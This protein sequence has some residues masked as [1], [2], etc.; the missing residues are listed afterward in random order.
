MYVF[1]CVCV[2]GCSDVVLRMSAHEYIV[3]PMHKIHSQGRVYRMCACVCACWYGALQ[4][5][6]YVVDPVYTIRT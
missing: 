4:L 1:A 5:Y 2:F 3:D 6:K